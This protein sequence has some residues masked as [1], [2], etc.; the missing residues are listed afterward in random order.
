MRS[1]TLNQKSMTIEE[2]IC[3][4][5]LNE[6]ACTELAKADRIDFD[7]FKLRDATENNELVTMLSYLVVNRGLLND[8]PVDFD[9]LM[10]YMVAIQNGYRN[11]TYHNTTHAADLC[12]TFNYFCRAGLE[13]K[14]ALD[15][16]ELTALFV[17]ACCHDYDHPGVNNSFLVNLHDPIALRHNDISVLE[18]HHIASSFEVMHRDSQR[19]WMAAYSK[20]NV[21]RLRKLMID[22]VF[23][24][25]II[26]H[27][28]DVA[29]FKSMIALK[30]YSPEKG[31]DK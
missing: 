7:V 1:D 16:N 28:G 5:K 11:V 25:D 9:K 30:E 27:F 8:S 14:C 4:L 13:Q 19:N 22:A 20:E 12:Q 29:Q 23:S 21:K 2:L 3:T 26:K 6:E 15:N 10:N 24:T 18:Q 17:A 31:E